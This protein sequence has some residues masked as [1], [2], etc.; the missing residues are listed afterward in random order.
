MRRSLR[1]GASAPWGGRSTH[2]TPAGRL[3]SG[4]RRDCIA[5]L[6]SACSRRTTRRRPWER[7]HRD[8]SAS[9]LVPLGGSIPDQGSTTC[10]FNPS[11]FAQMTAPLIGGTPVF[12]FAFASLFGP[13]QNVLMIRDSDIFRDER[14]GLA[15][16]ARFVHNAADW[17]AESQSTV[18]EPATVALLG[19]GLAGIGFIA[20]RRRG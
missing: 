5:G 7:L 19:G 12:D 3:A 11:P 6:R 18:P 16:N 2:D 8:W 20:R 15:D 1:S 10:G 4:V 17:L 9:L 13:Q 14:A